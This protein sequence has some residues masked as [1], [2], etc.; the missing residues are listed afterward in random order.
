MFL[1]TWNDNSYIFE[2]LYNLEVY[3]NKFKNNEAE[4]YDNISIY[5]KDK[6]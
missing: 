2:F 1:I 4:N 6:V 5:D 3:K